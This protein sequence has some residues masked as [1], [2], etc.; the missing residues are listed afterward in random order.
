MKKTHPPSRFFSIA[1]AGQMREKRETF[2]AI[3]RKLGI[4]DRKNGVFGVFF[5]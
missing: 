5:I 1:A 2:S 4:F 3:R